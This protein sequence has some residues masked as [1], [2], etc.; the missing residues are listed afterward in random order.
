MLKVEHI[1]IAVKSLAVS[2]PLFEKLLNAE[3]YKTEEIA[4]EGV[5]TAFFRQGETKIE[6]L[7]PQSDSS[8]VAKFLEKR[9]EGVHHLAFEV[10]DIRAEMAR[11]QK[12]GFELLNAEPKP[13][14]DNKL[15][16]FLHPKGTGGVLVELTQERS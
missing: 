10:S 8:P 14:A 6:L 11:L 13:G 12:E 3:C 9:G 2:V 5:S 7:E 15:V 4:S 16:C 1:G